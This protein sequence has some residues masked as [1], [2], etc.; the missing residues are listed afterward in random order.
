LRAREQVEEYIRSESP[1]FIKVIIDQLKNGSTPEEHL[2]LNEI[3]IEYTGTPQF[4]STSGYTKNNLRYIQ[5][6]AGV[7]Q[8]LSNFSSLLFEFL[9]YEGENF[10][11]S[12]V[13]SNKFMSLAT[14]LRTGDVQGSRK[15]AIDPDFLENYDFNSAIV[16]AYYSDNFKNSLLKFIVAHE[17]AHHL[18]GHFENN[19]NK[20]IQED[21]RRQIELD[22][23]QKAIEL[24]VKCDDQNAQF[25]LY[26]IMA[27]LA[28][29]Y[30]LDRIYGSCNFN[31][32]HPSTEKRFLLIIQYISNSNY[33]LD[34]CYINKLNLPSINKW[35]EYLDSFALA[36][37]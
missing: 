20:K 6:S 26:T 31:S 29:L 11:E 1:D 2:I 16:N 12:I 13:L 19:N 15:P 32:L 10:A 21:Y 5:I 30:T 17:C 35:L 7:E 36:F 27:W 24:I 33:L 22:A 34:S 3:K 25:N 28:F 14:T 9:F 8:I 23:D 18:L 37:Y 4:S